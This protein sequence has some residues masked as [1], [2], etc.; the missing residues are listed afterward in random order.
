V[1]SNDLEN[2]SKVVQ[3]NLENKGRI[4]D[5]LTQQTLWTKLIYD[6]DPEIFDDVE[7]L[8]N[9]LISKTKELLETHMNF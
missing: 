2:A 6:I 3:Q 4:M 7:N 1:N 8:Q 5:F 9:N